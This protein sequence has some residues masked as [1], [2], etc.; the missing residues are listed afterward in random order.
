MDYFTLF[1]TVKE[2]SGGSFASRVWIFR[3]PHQGILTEGEG[4][5]RLTSV[6]ELVLISC[7]FNTEKLLF[8]LF[9][10]WAFLIRRST[11]LSLPF[12]WEFPW[13]I[14]SHQERIFWMHAS[15]LLYS[16]L[17]CALNNRTKQNLKSKKKLLSSFFI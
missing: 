9:T 14:H 5:V 6:N 12:Q 10:K 3:E 2:I 11:V 1:K 13:H 17:V 8:I 16:S 7:F 4:S 15:S